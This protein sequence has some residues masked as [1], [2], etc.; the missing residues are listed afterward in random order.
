MTLRT[1]CCSYYFLSCLDHDAAQ[2]SLRPDRFRQLPLRR[3]YGGSA[4]GDAQ[5]RQGGKALVLRFV[6]RAFALQPADGLDAA[7][8]SSQHVR[9]GL[10]CAR[11]SEVQRAPRGE[12]L[13]FKSFVPRL[14]LPA[15]LQKLGYRTNAMVSLP[16]LNPATILNSGFDTYKLMGRH[17]DMRV[18]VPKN[19][20]LGGP[21][22]VSLAECRRNALPLRAA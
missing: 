9:V 22:V 10:L 3:V 5:V 13:D 7:Y 11:F 4:E 2:Q 8:Q 16:V 1:F 12:G 14:Y 21:A 15:V 17:N 20:V 19:V 6:D 18:M